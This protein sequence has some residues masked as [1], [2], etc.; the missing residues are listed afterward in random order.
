MR[1]F[2]SRLLI[3]FCGM[4]RLAVYLT[5]AGL[6][7]LAGAEASGETV[8]TYSG[9]V[10][11]ETIDLNNDGTADFQVVRDEYQWDNY[12]LCN[13][14]CQMDYEVDASLEGVGSNGIAPGTFDSG[15]SVGSQLLYESNHWLATHEEHQRGDDFWLVNE[16][17][18]TE[19]LGLRF[20]IG[21]LDHYGWAKV[22]VIGPWQGNTLIEYAYEN[23]PGVSVQ[24]PEPST[25]ALLFMGAIGLLGYVWRRRRWHG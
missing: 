18:G 11:F 25:L 23:Q 2:T 5:F 20:Q 8:Y 1:L 10:N 16:S 17:L 13:L 9:Q 12:D 3:R 6:A 24:I 22:D 4:G 15:D 14:N 21:G 19:I 7:V